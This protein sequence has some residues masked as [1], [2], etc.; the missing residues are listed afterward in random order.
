MRGL[1]PLVL[2]SY[3]LYLSSLSIIIIIT[4]FLS[5]TIHNHPLAKHTKKENKKERQ[6]NDPPLLTPRWGTSFLFISRIN[7]PGDGRQR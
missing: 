7:V 6:P 1:M 2:S 3:L 4:F 5:L